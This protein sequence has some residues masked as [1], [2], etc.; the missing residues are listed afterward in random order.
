M[1]NEK[2]FIEVGAN[3]EGISIEAY[4]RA[5]FPKDKKYFVAVR[6]NI[7]YMICFAGQHKRESVDQTFEVFGKWFDADNSLTHLNGELKVESGKF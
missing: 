7:F 6:F 4:I 3:E 2:R 1:V 5:F